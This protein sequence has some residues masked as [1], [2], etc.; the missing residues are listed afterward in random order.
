[1]LIVARASS[2][3][4]RVHPSTMSIYLPSFVDQGSHTRQ[5]GCIPHTIDF[6]TNHG[7]SNPSS[8]SVFQEHT[9]MSRKSSPSSTG[10]TTCLR[11]G[12][13]WVRPVMAFT[14]GLCPVSTGSANQST[15]LVLVAPLPPTIRLFWMLGLGD[16]RISRRPSKLHSNLYEV[17]R[18]EWFSHCGKHAVPVNPVTMAVRGGVPTYRR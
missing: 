18:C 16:A 7:S 17:S 9:H 5:Q 3:T 11:A 14:H 1:M 8:R 13:N 10:M 4:P 12:I 15:S 2:Y 6:G